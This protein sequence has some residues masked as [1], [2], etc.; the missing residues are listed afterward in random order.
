AIGGY[1]GLSFSAVNEAYD[2]GSNAWAGR[3]P[4]P[5]ARYF[6]GAAAVAGKIYVVGGFNG[7]PVG[8]VEAYDTGANVW[9]GRSPML[10]ARQFPAVAAIGGLIY[11]AGGGNGSAL[12][13]VEAYDPVADAWTPRAAM[14]V[15]TEQAAA[16]VANGKLVVMGGLAGVATTAVWAYDPGTDTWSGQP[17][18]NVARMLVAGASL[19]NKLYTVGGTNGPNLATTEESLPGEPAMPPGAVYTFSATGQVAAACAALTVSNTGLA[20]GMTVCATMVVPSNTVSFPVTPATPAVALNVANPEP[21]YVNAGEAQS[22]RVS[23][24]NAGGA[25][26]YNLTLSAQVAGGA[27]ARSFVPG[28]FS[29]TLTGGALLSG[30]A[31]ATSALGPWTA[32]MP[33]AAV[34]EN[35]VLRWVVSALGPTASGEASFLVTIGGAGT[36][37]LPTSLS[38]TF[39]CDPAGT[40]GGDAGFSATGTGE[41]IAPPLVWLKVSDGSGLGNDIAN[42]IVA[43]ASGW[44]VAAGQQTQAGQGQNW[45][46]AQFN[47]AGQTGWVATHNGAVNSTDVAHAIAAGPGGSVY[48]AGAETVVIGQG[49]NWVVKKYGPLGAPVWNATYAG[50]GALSDRAQGIIVDPAGNAYVAGWETSVAGDT[51]IVVKGFA[52]ADGTVLGTVTIGAGNGV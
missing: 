18:L 20:V 4:M 17:S 15:A 12:S 48:I 23:F 9:A 6:A 35:F 46:V 31:W 11:A 29:L 36:Q 41:R 19:A 44:G 52:D 8:T 33:A 27:G 13:S 49:T 42:G 28:S 38:A 16:A 26:L 39:S 37:L 21:L 1:D 50:P 40:G 51:D 2:T 43:A 47:P 7:S 3:A 10:G 24:S 30:S 45:R 5:T 25:T 22:W 34:G 32:G 14:P